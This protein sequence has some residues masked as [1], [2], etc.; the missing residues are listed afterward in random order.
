[1]HSTIV[2][3]AYCKIKLGI[4]EAF[5]VIDDFNEIFLGHLLYNPY[6]LTF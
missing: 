5:V 1:M 6:L 3:K 4:A 2:L